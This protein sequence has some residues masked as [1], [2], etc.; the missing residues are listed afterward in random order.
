MLRYVLAVAVLQTI[1]HIPLNQDG[2]NRISQCSAVITGSI[3]SKIFTIDT[4][5]SPVRARYEVPFVSLNSDLYSTSVSALVCE[6]SHY[7]GLHY[8]DTWLFIKTIFLTYGGQG[9]MAAI[10]HCI[11]LNVNVWIS[12]RISL[13]FVSRCP[14]NNSPALVWIMAWHRPG[15]KPLSESMV[16]WFINAYMHHSAWISQNIVFY[17]CQ[18][19]NPLA[20]TNRVYSVYTHQFQWQPIFDCGKMFL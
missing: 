20:R 1:Q 13:K 19:D 9:K 11:F 14:I 7:I 16:A 17:W 2:R 3:F 6:I 18:K 5:M 12:I 15:N 4:H 8:N 10:L